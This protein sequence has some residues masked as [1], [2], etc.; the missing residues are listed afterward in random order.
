MNKAELVSGVAAYSNLGKTEVEKV[1]DSFMRV[2]SEELGKGGD[3]RLVGFG[4]FSVSERA[5]MSGRNPKTGES[6][7]IPGKIIP[8]FKPGKQLKDACEMKECSCKAGDKSCS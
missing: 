1:I 6:I 3:I 8:K 5:P 4:T 2:V 7:S